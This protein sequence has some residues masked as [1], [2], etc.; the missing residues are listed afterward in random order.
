MTLDG[1]RWTR[2]QQLF[3][4]LREVP[5]HERA[6]GLAEL[7]RTDAALASDL[8]SLLDAEDISHCPRGNGEEMGPIFPV[9]LAGGQELEE[10]FVDEVRRCQRVFRPL[11]TEPPASNA[12]QL[13]IDARK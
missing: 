8:R 3:A 12:L 5:P 2:L 10:R 13:A 7:E 4:E 1:E 11:M 9:N 6:R